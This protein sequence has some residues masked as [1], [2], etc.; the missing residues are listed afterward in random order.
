VNTPAANRRWQLEA[1]IGRVLVAGVTASTALLAVGLVLTLAVPSH[2][3]G[4]AVLQAG[5]VTLIL[6]PVLRVL[7]SFVSY[8]VERDWVFAGLTGFVLTLLLGSLAAAV[9]R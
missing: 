1:L 6:T 8:V 2:A 3:A 9:L 5:L 4:G 7:A